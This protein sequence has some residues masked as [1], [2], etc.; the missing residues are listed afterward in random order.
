MKKL[1]CIILSLAMV[2]CF[3]ACGDSGS[4]TGSEDGGSTDSA[5]VTEPT[6]IKFDAE[7]YSVGVD[8]YYSLA[9]N[10]TV[11]PADAKITYT[12]SDDTVCDISKKGELSGLK[13]GE[14]T[15]TAGSSDGSV[16]ATCKVKV[17]AYGT[18]IGFDAEY[19]GYTLEYGP[20]SVDG[21]I[22]NKR[23]NAVE[24]NLDADAR[25]VIIPQ[26]MA[27]GVDMA[28]AVAL[29]YGETA[30][31]DGWFY[32]FYGDINNKAGY[33]VVKNEPISASFEINKMPEGKY[34]ALI[35]SS[36]DYTS[37]KSYADRDTAAELKA[38]AI[39]KWFTDAEISDLASL[40]PERE[41]GVIEFEVKAGEK[42]YFEHLFH[43]N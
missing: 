14:V 41:F 8:D 11:E 15:V 31:S 13:A 29:D 36:R 27:E 25:L 28:G 23:P 12:V 39:A 43:I 1:L 24:M 17:V 7:S 32:K 16:S 26:D 18:I 30:N 34:Y 38:T 33:V 6:S 2:L 3:A 9:Q 4:G 5:A 10:I 22:R 20:N 19:D 35:V 21:G 37:H 40:F 42:Y